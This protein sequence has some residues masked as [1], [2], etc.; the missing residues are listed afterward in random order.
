MQASS[1]YYLA[2]F[3]CCRSLSCA[4]LK[5]LCVLGTLGASACTFIDHQSA[6]EIITNFSDTRPFS[7][8]S[9]LRVTIN[10]PVGHIIIEADPGEALYSL[11]VD[12]DASR[13]QPEAK[14]QE[15]HLDFRLRGDHSLDMDT[16][17]LRL[18]F[19]TGLK[20]FQLK[21]RLILR[22]SPKTKLDL[23]LR[24]G[25]GETKINL[26]RLTTR[27]LQIQSGVSSTFI[28]CDTPNLIACERLHMKAGVGEFEALQL[29]NLNFETLDFEGG[30][31]SSHLDF[32]G[33]WRR[34]ASVSVKMGIGELQIKL[35]REVGAQVESEKKFLSG[36]HLESFLQRGS[37][38]FSDNFDSSSIKLSFHLQT[39]IGSIRVKW[40]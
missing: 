9:D 29:G 24:A 32:G 37:T 31:G 39:G 17:R 12:Y 13:F 5:L 3:C 1:G 36:L 40:L 26:A 23:N 10:F 20:S 28:S 27:G 11:D 22:V 19:G 34:N 6:P 25:L 33:R 21:N 14:Y 16:D 2:F 38:Y 8:E 7:N 4:G 15:G 30:V 18:S 35:P